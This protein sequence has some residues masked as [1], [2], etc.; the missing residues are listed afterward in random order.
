MVVFGSIGANPPS[1]AFPG[2][3]ANVRCRVERA[4]HIAVLHVAAALKTSLVTVGVVS[5]DE[6]DW[7]RQCLPDA[8]TPAVWREDRPA[9]HRDPSVMARQTP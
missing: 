2:P 4:R 1:T 7:R 8:K 3:I 9:V 6:L 5:G